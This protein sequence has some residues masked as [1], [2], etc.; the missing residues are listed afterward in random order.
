VSKLIISERAGAAPRLI[1]EG[2]AATEKLK[3]IAA[4]ANIAKC[5]IFILLNAIATEWRIKNIVQK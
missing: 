3:E 1:C 4:R 2:C 5:F